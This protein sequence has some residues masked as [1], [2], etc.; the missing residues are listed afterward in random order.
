MAK[1]NTLYPK[2]KTRQLQNEINFY[3]SGRKID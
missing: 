1:S 2:L 3:I